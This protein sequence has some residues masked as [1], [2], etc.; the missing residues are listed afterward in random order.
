MA[1]MDLSFLIEL[2]SNNSP[3]VLMKQIL[4][5]LESHNIRRAARVLRLNEPELAAAS[6]ETGEENQENEEDPHNEEANQQDV[7][8]DP[9]ESEEML[10]M[11][12]SKKRL[13]PGFKWHRS[14]FSY[15][16]PVSLRDLGKIRSGRSEYAAAFLNKV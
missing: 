10:E 2:D 1:K 9:A 11:L 12:K 3:T 4:H 13:A 8:I 14:K 6:E 5:R 15:I 16:C 7:Y